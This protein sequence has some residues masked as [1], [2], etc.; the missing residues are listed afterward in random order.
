MITTLCT[1]VI[2][3]TGPAS[4]KTEPCDNIQCRRFYQDAWINGYYRPIIMFNL[5]KKYTLN[6]GRVCVGMVEDEP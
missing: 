5:A 3:G 6:D 2:L 1:I 4:T